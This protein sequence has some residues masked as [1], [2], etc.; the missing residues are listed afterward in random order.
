M[1]GA[2]NRKTNVPS[3]LASAKFVF[4][5]KEAKSPLE[6]PYEGPYEVVNK[7]EKYYALQVGSRQEKV[8]IGRLKT[9]FVDNE[10]P[11][12][13][14]QP[15]RRGRP[16]GQPANAHQAAL[17]NAAH[18]GTRARGQQPPWQKTHDPHPSPPT[19]AEV[20]T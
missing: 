3:S 11:V 8:S 19:Y 15:P 1:H 6:L 5:R 14:A 20:T 18:Q 2:E 10:R 17:S 9:A 7:E 16:P 4:I 13:V 12:T